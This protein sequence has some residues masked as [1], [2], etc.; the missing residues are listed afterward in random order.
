MEWRNPSPALLRR[1]PSPRGEG[2]HFSSAFKLRKPPSP[3][4]RGWSFLVRVQVTKTALS[5]GERVARCP[6]ALHREAGRVRGYLKRARRPGQ[7]S[8]QAHCSV[9]EQLW[10]KRPQPNG[11]E[12]S[13][14]PYFGHSGQRAS[15]WLAIEEIGTVCPSVPVFAGCSRLAGA[16]GG[17]ASGNPPPARS[18]WRAR[19]FS[20]S[21]WR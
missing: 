21:A 5:L 14:A 15:A 19:V 13:G 12:R 7:R 3:L 10:P 2:G 16:A 1:A 4:G 6:D 9:P 8:P 17:A 11:S 18:F 20:W